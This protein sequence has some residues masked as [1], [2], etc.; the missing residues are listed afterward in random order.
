MT[1]GWISKIERKI[2]RSLWHC[3]IS[4]VT[5]NFQ[6]IRS[7][8]WGSCRL[9][10]SEMVAYDWS[11]AITGRKRDS[12]SSEG[13]EREERSTYRE[14]A[15]PIDS[16][17]LAQFHRSKSWQIWVNCLSTQR[18]EETARRNSMKEMIGTW[19]L[20]ERGRKRWKRRSNFESETSL[21]LRQ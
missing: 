4:R 3:C 12:R 2:E 20:W 8:S 14:G 17:S 21:I 18:G 10:K 5:V 15:S 19:N 11:D 13:R 7:L 16:I 9:H 6:D 1:S